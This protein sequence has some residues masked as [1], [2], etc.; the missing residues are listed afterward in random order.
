MSSA[1]ETT[2]DYNHTEPFPHQ[3]TGDDIPPRLMDVVLATAPLLN[4]LAPDRTRAAIAALVTA[5]DFQATAHYSVAGSCD[6][7]DAV[8]ISVLNPKP[9]VTGPAVAFEFMGL[10][11]NAALSVE[12][13]ENPSVIVQECPTKEFLA[14]LASVTEFQYAF[15]RWMRS[16]PHPTTPLPTLPEEFDGDKFGKGRRKRCTFTVQW[17]VSL[18]VGP[19]THSEVVTKTHTVWTPCCEGE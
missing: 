3:F 9:P 14:W 6:D 5:I 13:F 8:K 18:A 16:M 15:T 10:K 7:L 17:Q 12:I 2:I 4:A 19:V 11:L 1:T